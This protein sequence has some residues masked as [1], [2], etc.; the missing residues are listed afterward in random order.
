MYTTA[1]VPGLLNRFNV[2]RRS[3]GEAK[4]IT[5]SS[6]RIKTIQKR[7]IVLRKYIMRY[8]CIDGLTLLVMAGI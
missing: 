6:S 4:K 7:N 1:V 3:T 8:Y 2:Q 5:K